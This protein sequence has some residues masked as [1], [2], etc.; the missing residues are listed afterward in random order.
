M[1]STVFSAACVAC[2]LA[3]A[4]ISVAAEEVPLTH[5]PGKFITQRKKTPFKNINL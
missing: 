1:G 3:I 4:Q 2:V 5:K